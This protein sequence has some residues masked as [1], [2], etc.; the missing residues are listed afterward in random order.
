MN[1]NFC[2]FY[3]ILEF[4][5]TYFGK[6]T[7]IFI[8]KEKIS[9]LK[10]KYA[11]DKVSAYLKYEEGVK[12]GDRV[13][14]FANNCWEYVATIFAISKLGAIVVPINN[15]LKSKELSYLLND[16]KV[17]ILFTSDELRTIIEGSSASI[18]CKKIIWFGNDIK[19]TRFNAIL[20]YSKKVSK[21]KV[22]LD[23]KAVIFYTSGTTGIPK[24]ALLTNKNIFSN[25]KAINSALN[26]TNK[27][28]VL[29]FLPFYHS[30]IFTVNLL[31]PIY[32]G[33]SIVI[34][35]S[36]N[37]KDII[38]KILKKRVTIFVAIPEVYK[39]LAKAKL[40]WFFYKFNKI[41]YFVSG[42]SSLNKETL[43][44]MHKKFPKAVLIEGYGLSETSP[45]VT[46]NLDT[47]NKP[48]SVGKPI[49]GCKIKIVDSSGNQLKANQIGEI[50]VN[51]DNVM[52]SYYNNK[53]K[54]RNVLKDGWLYT[55]DLG[56]LDNDGNLY[57]VDRK[58]D[59]II[60]KGINIYPKEIEKVINRFYGVKDSAIIGLKNEK[61]EEIPV[62]FIELED[63]MQINIDKLKEHIKGFLADYKV[64]K[65]F[66]II[67]ELPR[68]T[69]RK[70][71][72]NKLRKNLKKYL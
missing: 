26:L 71:L 36:F 63:E 38:L 53:E 7:A 51:G 54:T 41:K 69:T 30:Y 45:V 22:S 35:T 58:K 62:A 34:P 12:K 49:N 19:C 67:D 57:I 42:S 5:A 70:V 56:Y 28:R 40:P 60:Y 61:D 1:N 52:I 31:T 39:A 37:F 11:A 72:K 9:Y 47:I 4:N 50:L 24:G 32:I 33:A 59:V 68:T 15:M 10:L 43:S 48:N 46:F 25:L 16:A 20:N 65:K 8:D 64:P 14:I 66:I 27:E 2:S 6:K 18:H 29:L 13:A 23:D 55:G 3:D 17:D 44:L 21:E